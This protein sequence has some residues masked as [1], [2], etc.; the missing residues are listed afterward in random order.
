M[1][2]IDL[3]NG[4]AAQLPANRGTKPLREAV[5]DV[6]QNYVADLAQLSTAD[7]ASS[8][9]ASARPRV[10]ALTEELSLTLDLLVRGK[11]TLAFQRLDSALSAVRPEL[12][13]LTSLPVDEA[14][15]G[16]LYRMRTGGGLDRYSRRQ[17]FHIPFEER[18]KVGPQR[19]SVIGVPMLY[20]GSSVYICWE[21]LGRPDHDSVWVSRYEVK[22]G[23]SVR[24]LNF[25]C[26]PAL[27]AALLHRHGLRTQR[28]AIGDFV[29]SYAVVWPIIAACSF[30]AVH[31][32]AKYVEEYAVPQ[33]LM[34][35]LAETEQYHGIRYFSTHVLY[36]GAEVISM[37]LVFPTRDSGDV[38]YCTYLAQ[39]FNATDP[40]SWAVARTAGDVASPLT[41]DRS[42]SIE[43][44]P[45]YKIPYGRSEY[46]L[47][48]SR[49]DNL[50]TGSI[51]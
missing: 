38:G 51:C 3:L 43:L 41:H 17:L 9:I 23:S 7:Y 24:L 26:T 48:E 45:G 31:R 50:K 12:D 19:Y 22:R 20:L 4:P 6:F 40:I 21:E 30:T 13:A 27:M 8:L 37:N 15:I 34:S 46:A 39:L 18:H 36:H 10:E 1:D 44:V 5:V 29:A 28:T 16:K 32:D 11:S 49:L 33:L 14:Q 42:S 25:G 2:A 47:M 35:W